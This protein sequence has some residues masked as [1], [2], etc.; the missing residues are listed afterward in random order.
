MSFAAMKDF[1]AHSSR[2]TALWAARSDRQAARS[3]GKRYSADDDDEEWEDDARLV[4]RG[5]FPS[6]SPNRARAR[7]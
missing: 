3:G 1:T 2:R 6:R 5:R 7:S 4:R